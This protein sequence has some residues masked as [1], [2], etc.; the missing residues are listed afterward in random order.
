MTTKKVLIFFLISVCST[1]LWV[2][3]LSK[4]VADED[5]S[6][7][8]GEYGVVESI[9]LIPPRGCAFVHMNRRMDAY[10]ALKE[11]HKYKLHGKPIT[12]RKTTR[13]MI[14][15]EQQKTKQKKTVCTQ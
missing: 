9:N 4:L 15:L 11:L 2:G 13:I 7:L 10:K 1:T 6:D 3:H 8:F 5:L 14:K 12:V